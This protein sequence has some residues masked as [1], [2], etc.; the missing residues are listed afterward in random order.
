MKKIDL[1]NKPTIFIASSGKSKS[2][3][4]AIKLNFDNEADV[5]IWTENIFKLN[6]GTLETLM[7]RSSYYDFFIAVFTADD[8]AT[9]NN[10]KTNITRDNVIFEFGL[11]L[12]RIGLDRTFF[13]LE[14]KVKLFT[15]WN[16]ITT[17]TFTRRG[18]LAAALG[19]SCTRIREQMNIAGD[20]FNYTILPST[21]LAVGYYNNFLKPVLEALDNQKTIEII[22]ERDKSGKVIKKIDYELKKPYPTIE[23]KVPRKLATLQRDIINRKTSNYKQIVLSAVSRPFPFYINGKFE[24]NSKINIFDIPTTLYASYLTIKQF[25]KPSFLAAENNEQKLIDKEIKNFQKTLSKLIPDGIES[26]FYKFIVY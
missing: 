17:T 12:G 22:V 6:E 14:D 2:I 1:I 13:V 23:I 16:G 7:N 3:A 11:F 8:V 19:S 10:K 24:Q 20:L 26:K 4:E 18:N 9:I 15:D 21:S 25:F 5:D